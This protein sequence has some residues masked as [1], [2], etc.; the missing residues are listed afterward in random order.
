MKARQVLKTAAARDV[1]RGEAGRGTLNKVS[2]RSGDGYIPQVS[3]KGP[4]GQVHNVAHLLPVIELE[5]S[6]RYLD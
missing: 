3:P 6:A 5:M 1:G 2:V 4:H